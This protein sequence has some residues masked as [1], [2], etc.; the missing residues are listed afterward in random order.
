M[1]GARRRAAAR[2]REVTAAR[3]LQAERIL[4]S[5]SEALV[6]FKLR[7]VVRDGDTWPEERKKL[8]ALLGCARGGGG[9]VPAGAG[10]C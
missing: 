1:A 5:V 9:A 4:D 7:K 8:C 3:D 6:A 10:D 2:V